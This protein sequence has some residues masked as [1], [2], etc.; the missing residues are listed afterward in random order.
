M[1]GN[2]KKNVCPNSRIHYLM[3]Y[4]AAIGF[5]SFIFRCHNK[6]IYLHLGQ[7]SVYIFVYYFTFFHKFGAYFIL[8]LISSALFINFAD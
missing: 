5:V 2:L 3:A 4:F 8:K 7:E 1:S 6:N